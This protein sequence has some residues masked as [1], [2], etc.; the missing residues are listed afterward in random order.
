VV[1]DLHLFDPTLGTSGSA[2]EDYLLENRKLIA[3]SEEI[4]RSLMQLILSD[5][6]EI[7]LITGDLTKDGE[8]RSHTML[9]EY[10]GMLE[11]A[12]K[13]VFVVPGNHDINNLNSV[14]Y[15][16]GDEISVPSV[17][18]GEFAEI[19]HDY[20]YGEALSRDT[21]SLSYIVEPRK[22]LWIMAMDSCRYE[23]IPS[24]GGGFS[25]STLQ[26]ILLNL[27]KARSMHITV[28][29]MMHHGLVNHFNAQSLFFPDYVIDGWKGVS[30]DFADMEMNVVFTGHFHAQDIVKRVSDNGGFIFDVETGS[31]I[32]Y[33][34]PLRIVQLKGDGRLAI[35]SRRISEINYDTV[36]NSFEEYAK[37]FLE[38]GLEDTMV[39]SL[40]DQ[41]Q[42]SHSD[43]R[44][45]AP[46]IGLIAHY[47]GDESPSPQTRDIIDQ[48]SEDMDL[49]KQMLGIGL[50]SIW[51]DPPPGFGFGD[52]V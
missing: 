50:E 49:R 30:D 46:H 22:G 12:G 9:A 4:L 14:G 24:T 38:Y 45:F 51:T 13:Q 41:F 3:E 47:G 26:W 19:Y 8:R 6:V 32:T 39:E 20:G 1:S 5:D 37:D 7:V 43:A 44:Q 23:G 52:S 34:C 42:L 15:S 2:F 35:S 48:L 31:M 21:V 33:P 17:S 28:F 18:A 16:G 40:S 10:L 29:G 36:G 27:E 25:E 11:S